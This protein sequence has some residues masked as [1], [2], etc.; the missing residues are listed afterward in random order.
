MAGVHGV[1]VMF[2]IF[3]M[4]V[5]F[6][7]LSAILLTRHLLHSDSDHTFVSSQPN[8]KRDI[9]N[10]LHC[11]LVSIFVYPQLLRLTPA[12]VQC[13]QSQQYGPGVQCPPAPHPPAPGRGSDAP[14]ARGCYP[15][16]SRL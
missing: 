8:W 10:Y 5:M 2:V 1:F 3:V 9:S 13:P 4:F 15:P 7:M 14:S 6:V 16:D 11:S 12:S